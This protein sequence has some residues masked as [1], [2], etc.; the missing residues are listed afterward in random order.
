MNTKRLISTTM[1]KSKIIFY[2]F[3]KPKNR[4]VSN[5]TLKSSLQKK[6]HIFLSIL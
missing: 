6:V 1:S 5:N 2:W 3:I 4:N